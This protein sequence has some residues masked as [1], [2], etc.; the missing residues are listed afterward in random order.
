MTLLTLVR[1]EQVAP[2][3]FE[4]Q[5]IEGPEYTAPYPDR[6]TTMCEADMPPPIRD[7]WQALQIYEDSDS[8]GWVDGVGKKVRPGRWWVEIP[9]GID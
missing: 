1:V 4:L 3:R 8:S 2:D 5:V 7:R 9:T 6:A